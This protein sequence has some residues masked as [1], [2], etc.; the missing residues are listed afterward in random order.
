M[1]VLYQLCKWFKCF[2]TYSIKTHFIK[3]FYCF[4]IFFSDHGSQE[5]TDGIFISHLNLCQENVLKIISYGIKFFKNIILSVLKDNI[6]KNITNIYFYDIQIRYDQQLKVSFHPLSV[7]RHLST[8]PFLPTQD[9]PAAL[10]FFLIALCKWRVQV[11]AFCKITVNCQ[12]LETQTFDLL[13]ELYT[14]AEYS[15][16]SFMDYCL[17]LT[18]F[19]KMTFSL[20]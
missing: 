1:E 3:T 8:P 15:F 4:C 2:S 17:I 14:S 7:K 10:I 19:V 20:S 11:T 13:C 12:W 9:A 18:T 16:I 6:E 5:Y